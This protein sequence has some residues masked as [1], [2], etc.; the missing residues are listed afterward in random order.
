MADQGSRY[1]QSTKFCDVVLKGG[2]TSGVVYPL[3][4]ASLAE[5]VHPQGL[6]AVC[7][8]VERPLDDLLATRPRLL[9]VCA[10]VR[11]PGNAGT[12][13]RCAD[14][15]GAGG[16]VLA[17]SS[18]DPFNGKT[19]RATAGSLFHL[20]V[21]VGGHLEDVLE[22]PHAEEA[23]DAA[24][25]DHRRRAPEP[26]QGGQVE[27]VVV[28]MGDEDCV[29]AA[30]GAGVDPHAAAQMRDAGPQQRVGEEADAVERDE[31]GRVPD[32]GDV[33]P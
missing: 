9:A 15:A 22:A 14:A 10:D 11:D 26:I 27:V 29:D 31:H 28:G 8:T 12:V 30:Q 13:I 1:R 5:T 21:A 20:P 33:I 16:V 6:V 25:R 7:R 4:L 17:G 18:V 24:R 32:E 23:A 19:V 3:A 2:I